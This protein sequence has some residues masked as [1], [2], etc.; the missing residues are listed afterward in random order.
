VERGAQHVEALGAGRDRGA[1]ETGVAGQRARA[2]NPGHPRQHPARHRPQARTPGAPA[3][4]PVPRKG[5]PGPVPGGRPI[6]EAEPAPSL[7]T[8]EHPLGDKPAAAKILGIS[9]KTLY[10]RLN[11]YKATPA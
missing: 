6:A 4:G 11:V 2:Q 7:A 5:S 10:N 3:T 9:L 1:R 8:L